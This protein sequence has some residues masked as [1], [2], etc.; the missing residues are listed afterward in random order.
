MKDE[1]ELASLI[2]HRMLNLI[3]LTEQLTLLMR[4][5]KNTYSRKFHMEEH[6]DN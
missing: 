2:L 5:K 4:R 3:K 1:P 6:S